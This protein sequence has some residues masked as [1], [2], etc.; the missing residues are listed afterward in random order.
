M[1]LL[2]TQFDPTGRAKLKKPPKPKRPAR[3]AL[4]LL[5][6]IVAATLVMAMLAVAAPM[7]IR[8]A[9]IWKQTR[10]YQFAG[11][12]LAGQMDRLVAMSAE[13]RERA[14]EQMTVSPDVQDVLHEAALEGKSL[15][16]EDGKRIQLS[17]NWQREGAPRPVTLIA[18]I[19]P[20]PESAAE[21]N[22]ESPSDDLPSDSDDSDDG[23]DKTA[24]A[25]PANQTESDQ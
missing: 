5:E 11:D 14:L 12:E 2:K 6:T 18:W 15:Q 25:E 19:D 21:S 8:S 24:D 7:V 10:H 1:H 9:R 22:A 16:D 3:N 20:L 23:V 13:E 17:I 4:V